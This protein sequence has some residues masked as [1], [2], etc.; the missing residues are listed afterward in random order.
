MIIIIKNE[1]RK[2]GMIEKEILFPRSP[3]I[4]GIN[5]DPT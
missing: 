2:I 4:G 5:V 3:K 1:R